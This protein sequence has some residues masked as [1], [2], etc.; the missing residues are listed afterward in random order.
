MPQSP[1]VKQPLAPQAPGGSGA[2]KMGEFTRM[3]GK[4]DMAATPP[5]AAA[6][7]VA[8]KEPGEFTRMFQAPV[9]GGPTPP[10]PPAAPLPSTPVAI[11][12]SM[13]PAMQPA[14]APP[15]FSKPAGPGEYTRQFS[16]PAQL[17]LGQTSATPS[18]PAPPP[19]A[20][21]APTTPMA[22]APAPPPVRKSNLPLI[23]GIAAIVL[24]A[25]LVVIFFAMRPK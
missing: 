11:P 10:Q 9:A 18:V 25:V 19:P 8:P 6:P 22:V 24:I 20:F 14:P 21:A 12:S 1:A 5:A 13:Q 7:P 2:N 15:A 17:T 4:V 3:F 16:A 23:I